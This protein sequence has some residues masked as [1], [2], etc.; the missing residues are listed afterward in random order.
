MSLLYIIACGGDR[1]LYSIFHREKDSLL[2]FEDFRHQ[3]QWVVSS[4][5]F[6]CGGIFV[7]NQ[8]TALQFPLAHV[9]EGKQ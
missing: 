4:L 3:T 6:L 5:A 1:F 9:S 7:G 8:R 2:P